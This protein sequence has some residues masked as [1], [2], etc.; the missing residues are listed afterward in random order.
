MNLKQFAV[1]FGSMIVFLVS[2]SLFS[3]ISD[4]AHQLISELVSL[5]SVGVVV[6]CSLA[7]VWLMGEFAGHD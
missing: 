5:Y 3:Q 6:G 1:F 2:V 7:V 4:H